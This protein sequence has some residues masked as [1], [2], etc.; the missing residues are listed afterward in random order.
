VLLDLFR[1]L[2]RPALTVYLCVLSTLIYYQ[3]RELIAQQ[4]LKPDQALQIE[5][6]IVGTILY[7]TTTCVLW[8]F[9]TRNKQQVPKLG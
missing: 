7:L 1:G 6:L 2:V 8:R 4:P 3:A 9:G 5:N